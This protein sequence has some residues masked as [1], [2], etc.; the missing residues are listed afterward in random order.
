MKQNKLQLL[1]FTIGGTR[2]GID[3][4]QIACLQNYDPTWQGLIFHELVAATPVVYV[5]PKILRV[6]NRETNPEV[7]I[8]DPEEMIN[9]SVTAIRPLPVLLAYAANCRGVW[10][11]IP[12]QRG[13]IVLFD[14]YK[15]ERFCQG[16]I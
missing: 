4:D 11:I 9:T 10:G 8:N 7:L 15:N 6:K 12:H 14:F 5:D 2:Y 3:T 1:V 16:T 13:L